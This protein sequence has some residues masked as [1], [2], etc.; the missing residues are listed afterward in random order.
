MSAAAAPALRLAFLATRA[1]IIVRF[2][3]L[4]AGPGAAFFNEATAAPF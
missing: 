3:S 2:W 4:P 1:R